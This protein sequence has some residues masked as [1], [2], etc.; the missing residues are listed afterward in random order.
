MAKYTANYAPI[1]DKKG[2]TTHFRHPVM[3][4][5]AGKYGLKVHR[6]LGTDSQEEAEKLIDMLNVMMSDEY[7][8]DI[9]KKPEAYKRFPSII[10]DIFYDPMEIEANKP[11]DLSEYHNKIYLPNKRDGY[12]YVVLT[13]SSGAGKTSILRVLCGTV[14]K[15]FPCTSAGRTTTAETEIIMSADDNYEVVVTFISRAMLEQHVQ[16]C[17]EAAVEYVIEYDVESSGES[18]ES[19]EDS[20]ILDKLFQHKDLLLR[21]NYILGELNTD[22]S[23]NEY[24]SYEEED[25]EIA[26]SDAYEDEGESMFVHCDDSLKNYIGKIKRLAAKNMGKPDSKETSEE[27]GKPLEER[28]QEDDESLELKTEIIEAVQARFQLLKNGEKLN[29]NGTWVNAWYFK[30]TDRDKFI[31]VVKM[32]SDNSKKKWGNLLTPIVSTMRIKGDFSPKFGDNNRKTVLYDGMGLGHKT[33]VSSIPTTLVNKFLQADSII[34]VDTAKAPLLDNV[35]L[36]VKTLIEGGHSGKL[37]FCYTHM[38]QMSGDNFANDKDKIKHVRSAIRGYLEH[39][40]KQEPNLFSNFE[41]DQMLSSCYYLA[42]L[43]KGCRNSTQSQLEKALCRVNE[44]SAQPIQSNNIQISY[45]T[46]SLYSHMQIAIEKYRRSWSEI[47]GHPLKTSQT[48]HWSR[49]KA[50]SRRLAYMHCD[51]YNNELAPLADL[52]QSIREQMNICLNKPISVMPD[53]TPEDK[54]VSVINMIKRDIDSKMLEFIR[55][56]LWYDADQFRRWRAAYHYSGRY[57]TFD[58]A[59]KITRIFD[60]GA[61]RL[62]SFFYNM[63]DKQRIYAQQIINITANVITKHAGKIEDPLHIRE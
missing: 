51:N 58:R 5:K 17:I 10:V 20:E 16:D 36:A 8:W 18:G 25:A 12:K 22:A 57:S 63:T 40:K 46:I 9:S 39:L 50:L 15:A 6:G 1:K 24:A 13:G 27:T 37:L 7:W 48:E 60:I 2:F 29:K 62:D 61:P 4:D 21:L 23:E 54:K 34:L 56:E 43:N 45:D 28:L 44:Q 32:F 41:K 31:Q 47:V 49:I 33:A 55:E 53:E 52:A 19:I 11:Q 30:T 35:K 59:A 26:P 3:K 14:D 38:D 42:A